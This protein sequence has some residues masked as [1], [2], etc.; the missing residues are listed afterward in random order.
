[1]ENQTITTTNLIP[2]LTFHY[3]TK[4]TNYLHFKKTL[5]DYCIEHFK[6]IRSSILT[7]NLEAAPQAPADLGNAPNN[8]QLHIW[9]TEYDRAIIRITK[10]EEELRELFELIRRHLSNESRYEVEHHPDYQT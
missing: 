4:I 5:G 8:M 2:I 3:A 10:R 6:E 1:M 7:G 9:K